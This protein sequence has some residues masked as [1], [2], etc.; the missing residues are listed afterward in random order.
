MIKITNISQENLESMSRNELIRLCE[1]MGIEVLPRVNK[2]ML[3]DDILDQLEQ[4]GA[5]PLSNFGTE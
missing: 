4:K 5:F 1:I 2:E 3:V